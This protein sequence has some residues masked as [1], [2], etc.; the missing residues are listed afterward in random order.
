MAEEVEEMLLLTPQQVPSPPNIE[1]DLELSDES[2]VK[3]E[4]VPFNL[5]T[6]QEL[7][8]LTLELDLSEDSSDDEAAMVPKE[9]KKT[10]DN[11]NTTEETTTHISTILTE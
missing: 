4:T 1:Q 3:L 9:M 2:D 7:A 11:Q 6:K 5:P 8:T 10:E